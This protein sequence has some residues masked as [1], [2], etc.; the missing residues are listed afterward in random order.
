[1]FDL[2]LQVLHLLLAMARKSEFLLE[3]PEDGGPGL[4]R[5]L[6]QHVMQDDDLRSN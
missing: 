6:A 5:G 3:A 4:D 2:L 1:M